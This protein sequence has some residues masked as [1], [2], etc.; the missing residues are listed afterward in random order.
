MIQYYSIRKHSSGKKYGTAPP[1]IPVQGKGYGIASLGSPVHGRY[2]VQLN[3]V[4]STGYGYGAKAQGGHFPLGSAVQ[5]R[6]TV[7]LY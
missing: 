2:L 5:S 1:G 3:L 6:D 4:T 7:M